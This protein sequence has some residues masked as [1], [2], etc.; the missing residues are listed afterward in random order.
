MLKTIENNFESIIKDKKYAKYTPLRD[1]NIII[2]LLKKYN[3]KHYLEIGT[4]EG[5]G[6]L[7]VYDYVKNLKIDTIDLDN[8]S[9]VPQIQ[10]T[11]FPA[12]NIAIAIKPFEDKINILSGNSYIYKYL[13]RYDSVFIDG[14]HTKVIEDFRH[15]KDYLSYPALIIFHDYNNK[16]VQAVTDDINGLVKIYDQLDFYHIKDSWVVYTTLKGKV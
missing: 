4:Q 11:E 12:E 7:A 3:S 5:Y 14:D 8:P 16:P 15:I 2:G 9:M 13:N 1:L 6:C 10:M